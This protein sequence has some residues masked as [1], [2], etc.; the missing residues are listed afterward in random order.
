MPTIRLFECIV[1]CI[2]QWVVWTIYI[3]SIVKKI[4]VYLSIYLFV[5]L[6]ICTSIY[7]S[8]YLSIYPF[9]YQSQSLENS[10]VSDQLLL[11]F[12]IFHPFLHSFSSF[13]SKS[14]LS[15]CNQISK[16]LAEVVDMCTLSTYAFLTQM[17]EINDEQSDV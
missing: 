1:S 2:N 17:S 14:R 8:I 13:F 6:S 12:L 7:L 4:Y 15:I 11:A 9:A 3:H 5:C 16:Q 10:N